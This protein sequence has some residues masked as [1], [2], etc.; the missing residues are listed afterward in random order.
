MKI[1]PSLLSADFGNLERS[2][3]KVSD[4]EWLHIDVMDGHFVP[5]ITIGPVVIKSLRPYTNQV[6]DTHLMI[7]DPKKYLQAFIDA[8][9]DRI[10]FHYESVSDSLDIIKEIKTHGVKAGISIKPGTAVKEIDELLPE[11][12][13]ILIMSVEPGFGGQSFIPSAVDKISYLNQKRNEL[14]LSYEIVVDGGINQHT[15]QLCKE[16][17]VDVL[18]AGSY[19]FNSP[20]P[21]ERIRSLR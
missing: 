14:Q 4:A 7:A 6:F 9:S 8:G 16:A 19:V 12:D 21:S 1:A 11:L 17:G 13:Q 18:V 15:G 3:A 2:I 20:D 5:N 10:T